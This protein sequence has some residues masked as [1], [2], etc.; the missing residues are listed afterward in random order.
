MAPP[1]AALIAARGRGQGGHV[2]MVLSP[3][4][5]PWQFSDV[6]HPV[7]ILK[8]AAVEPLPLYGDGLNGRDWAYVEEALGCPPAGRLPGRPWSRHLDVRIWFQWNSYDV[9]ARQA[10]RV[11]A[12]TRRCWRNLQI[13][14]CPAAGPLPARLCSHPRLIAPFSGGSGYDSRYAIDCTRIRKELG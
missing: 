4:C 8:A 10:Q 1:R 3:N 5:G 13:S 2:E 6:S 12:A 9:A 14:R 7:V 11:N